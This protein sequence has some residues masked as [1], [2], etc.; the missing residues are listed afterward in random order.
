MTNLKPPCTKPHIGCLVCG[1]GEMV[2]QPDG[3]F[4]ASLDTVLYMGFGG[5]TIYRD[6]KAYYCPPINKTYD[7]YPRLAE[8]EAKAQADPDHDWQAVLNLPLRDAVYQRQGE[9]RWVLIETGEG[10]A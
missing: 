5:W 2:K 10:F 7:D 6:A 4:I 8:Y 9:G 1:G 3:T